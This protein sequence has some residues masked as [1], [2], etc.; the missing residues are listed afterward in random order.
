MATITNATRAWQSV[1][2]ATDEIWQ[3]RDGSVQID[4]DANEATRLGILMGL[5][6]SIALPSGTVFYRL[7]GGSSAI[8]ARVAV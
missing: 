1:T 2:L 4:T 7:G 3:V 6:D 5:N 8:V